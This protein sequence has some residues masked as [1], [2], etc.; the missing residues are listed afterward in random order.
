MSTP[1]APRTPTDDPASGPEHDGTD[2]FDRIAGSGAVRRTLTGAA[3]AARAMTAGRGGGGTAPTGAAGAG[4][5]HSWL[6]TGPPGSGRSVAALAFA[7]ALVCNDPG[8]TGCGRCTACRTALAGT[9]ADVIHVVPHEL[10]ISVKLM[11]DVIRDAS[12]RPTT[13]PWRVVV[14]EDADRLSDAAANALLK[15]VEEPP[16]RTVIIL[17]APSTDPRDIAI[18]LRS[19]CRHVYIPTPAIPDVARILVHEL[20]VTEGDAKLA[21]VA[22]A[23]H[24]G[25]ARNLVRSTAA[26]QRRAQVLGLA[27]L[28]YEGDLAFREVTNLIR[29]IE[30]EAGETLDALDERETE[31]L[32]VALGLGAK[33]K[34]TVK[35]LRGTRTE[36]R[37]LEERQKRRRTR[38]LRDALDLS[39]VDLAGLYR[40]ALLTS[41]GAQEVQRIHPDMAEIVDALA[42]RNTAEALVACLDAVTLCRESLGQ[43]VRPIVAM[44]ALVGRLR[45]ACGVS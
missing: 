36:I 43:S 33:G 14:I 37:E 35:A 11:R 21:A 29:T 9:H 5:T 38:Y 28:V 8:I 30:T 31:K 39:L 10:S 6:F 2:V 32:A 34:G 44:D 40:D 15:T 12:K 7:A 20:G 17:C 42:E 16:E 45:R 26:Q 1:N 23:G 27:R 13:A 18:T 4:M 25:R 3:D 19:R 22:S 24:I 41:S